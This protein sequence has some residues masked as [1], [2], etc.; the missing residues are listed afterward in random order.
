MATLTKVSVNGQVYDLGGSGGGSSMI[1]ITYS[2]LKSLVD[3]ASL[4]PETKY[5]ITDYVST[6]K[7]I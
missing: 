1:E 7:S 4:V 2:E 3:S 6:F 5:R